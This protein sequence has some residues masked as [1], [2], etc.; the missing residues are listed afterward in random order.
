MLGVDFVCNKTI[1]NC[2]HFLTFTAYSCLL[3]SA[4][5]NYYSLL[6]IKTYGGD[7]R[8]TGRKILGQK[9]HDFVFDE[10]FK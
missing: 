8:R 5:V 10:K 9:K 3:Y 1:I 7:G 2:C 4:I 6:Y